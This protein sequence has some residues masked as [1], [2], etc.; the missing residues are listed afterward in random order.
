LKEKSLLEKIAQLDEEYDEMV[1]EYENKI[2]EIGEEKKARNKENV[3]NLQTLLKVMPMY[4]LLIT[5]NS[6]ILKNPMRV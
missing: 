3:E 1:D 2:F 6:I 5:R 4:A